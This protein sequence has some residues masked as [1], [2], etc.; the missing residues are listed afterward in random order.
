MGGLPVTAKYVIHA[1]LEVEG[2]VEKPDV[3]GAIFGQTE[4]L[5]GEDLELRELQKIGRIGRIDVRLERKINKTI[6]IIRIPSTLDRVETALVAA[7]V[8]TVDRIGPYPARVSVEK[9][10]D[11]R[12]EKRKRIVERARELLRKWEEYVPETRE[13]IEEVLKGLKGEV[14]SYGPEKLPAG[15]DVDKADTII[16][17]EGRADVINLLKHGY[18][19][20]IALGG[21]AVPNTI[22]ELSKKKTTILFVDGDRGGELIVKNVLG[23]VHVDY[24]A[25]APQGRE[26]EE[27]TAKE[28]AKA[29][30][31]K[32][33]ASEYLK[34][35]PHKIST[36][37]KGVEIELPEDVKKSIAELKGT[38]EAIIY[39]ES[40][41]PLK[42]LPVRD[43]P[44]ELEK[45]EGAKYLVFDGIITQRIVD[46]AFKKGLEVLIGARIG[47]AARIP[48]SLTIATFKE[49]GV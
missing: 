16:L 41:K 22:I 34:G 49:V 7:A 24:V 38:L 12:I 8:E 40:W 39:G 14:I 29:L 4:G 5:L 31:S 17:V 20:V 25:R 48:S 27:L 10:E 37:P 44:E 35:A 30:K 21:A 45:I 36:K 9:I 1:K 28:I 3:I 18:R 26:V 32:V 2:I 33:P 11:V 47:D 15:P 43:L 19:N 6:G 46:I 42:K 23:V 13:L